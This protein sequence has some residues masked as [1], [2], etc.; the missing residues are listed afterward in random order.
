MDRKKQLKEQYKQMKPE[1]GIF[2][3]HC[4]AN[5][6][7]FLK[8]TQNL[9][10]T[11]NSTKFQLSAKNFPN[12][13]LQEDWNKYGQEQFEIEILEILQ[14]DKDESKTDYSEELNIMK[15]VWEEKLTKQNL[16]FYTEMF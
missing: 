10:G 15:I 14:Y 9:K 13:E 4:K 5:N 11:M 6:K 1:M 3:V 12:Y 8:I 2:M 16:E 7:C